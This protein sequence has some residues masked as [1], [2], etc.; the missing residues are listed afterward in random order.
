MVASIISVYGAR[1]WYSYLELVNILTAHEISWDGA[2][3]TL[4]ELLTLAPY[5]SRT[6]HAVSLY[7]NSIVAGASLLSFGPFFATIVSDFLE[8]AK[9]RK[10]SPTVM[11]ILQSF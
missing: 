5:L 1:A 11:G 10:F 2:S 4:L 8:N 7:T 9:K 6:T 3:I